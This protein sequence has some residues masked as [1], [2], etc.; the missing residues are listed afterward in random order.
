MPEKE[1]LTQTNEHDINRRKF[2]HQ[3]IAASS[4]ALLG[5]SYE[6]RNLLAKERKPS[7]KK[8]AFESAENMPMGKIGNIHVTR[9]IVGGNLTSGIAHSRDLI[10]VSPLVKNYFSD[11][12]IFETWELSE[13]CGINTAILRLDDQV[14]RLI[15]TYWKDRGWKLQWIVQIKPRNMDIQNFRTD[16]ERAIDN[17]AIGAYIQGNVADRLVK[18]KRLDL[19]EEALECIKQHKV[20][21]GIGGH[22]LEVPVA[23]ERAGL[24]PDFYL[25]TL[26]GRDYWTFN[27]GNDPWEKFHVSTGRTHDNVWC[28]EP[29]ETIEFMQKVKRPWIA[30]KVMAAGAIHPKHAFQYA[31]ENGA[32]FICAGMFDFQ[33]R[34]DAI[35]A[36]KILGK[37]SERAR[38]WFG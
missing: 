12:K 1:R 6:E 29:E 32:D 22:S 33:V 23:C 8:L 18:E 38:P 3:S 27:P 25:K 9:L 19:L 14:I 16:I 30:F 5:F 15:N 2:F 20:I 10:Y 11:E 7:P 36:K 21:A 31:Y 17:G 34:E 28:T 37:R 4:G 24:I 35:I 26:H 13:E